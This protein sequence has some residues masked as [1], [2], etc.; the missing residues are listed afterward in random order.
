MTGEHHRKPSFCTGPQQNRGNFSTLCRLQG[1]LYSRLCLRAEALES[2]LR[3]GP[4]WPTA[5]SAILVELPNLRSAG[6]VSP[7]ANRVTLS[8]TLGFCETQEMMC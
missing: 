6:L 1:M 5:R 7:S 3:S 2:D 4:A 8:T